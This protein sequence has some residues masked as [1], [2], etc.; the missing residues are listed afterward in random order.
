MKQPSCSIWFLVARTDVSFMMQ[1]IPHIIRMCNYPFSQKVLAIDTSPLSG[2]YTSRPCIGTF[3]QLQKCCENLLA[4]GIIDM[5][6]NVDF[7]KKYQEKV[8]RKHLGKFI[9]QTHNFRG[10]PVLGYIF[11]LEEA[12]SDYL[13]HFNTDMLIY[14]NPNYNWVEEGIKKMCQYPEIACVTPLSGPPSEDGSLHQKVPYARDPGGFYRFKEFTSRKFLVDIKRF[15]KLLPLRI[16]WKSISR[17]SNSSQQMIVDPF[18]A[19]KELDRWENMV[20]GRLRETPYFRI[21]IDTCSAWAV[22]SS[23]N[24]DHA[25]VKNLPRIIYKIESGWYPPEQAGHYNLLSE[26]WL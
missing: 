25:F 18:T 15:E 26:L 6:V 20:S 23:Q 7:S 2:A 9:R 21:D 3:T 19:E 13:L 10:A 16:L 17:C 14:Q 4:C 5:I 22:H 24:H 11:M 8:Y 1:T 12:K